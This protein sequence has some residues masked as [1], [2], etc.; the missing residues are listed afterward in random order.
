MSVRGRELSR[1][2]T[3]VE[4]D[5]RCL[6]ARLHYRFL[7][8]PSPLSF[9]SLLL[10]LRLVE[11]ADWFSS[12]LPSMQ[13]TH[14]RQ[15][16]QACSLRVPLRSELQAT[17]FSPSPPP[18]GSSPRSSL[19][20][21]FAS[22][23]MENACEVECERCSDRGSLKSGSQ[24]ALSVAANT[25]WSSYRATDTGTLSPGPLL[26]GSNSASNPPNFS[27]SPSGSSQ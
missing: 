21:V 2:T 16:Q 20:C 23:S 4:V 9:S 25:A 14:P 8:F 1:S 19:L 11:E 12:S 17:S 5:V 26:P 15:G 3:T 18:T 27:L 6:T 22:S 7:L 13:R 10:F 24:R